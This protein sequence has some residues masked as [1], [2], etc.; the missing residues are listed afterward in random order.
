MSNNG[1]DF[2]KR[3]ILFLTNRNV[4]LQRTVDLLRN[5]LKIQRRLT[6]FCFGGVLSGFYLYLFLQGREKK[7][8]L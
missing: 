6:T 1:A 5:K 2:F 7:Q 3:R 8:S 4:E